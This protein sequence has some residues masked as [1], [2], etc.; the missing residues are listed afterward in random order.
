LTQRAGSLS[1]ITR[2]STRTGPGEDVLATLDI[3]SRDLDRQIPEVLV[4][5]RHH[6]NLGA[7]ELAAVGSERRETGLIE[8]ITNQ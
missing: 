1:H 4:R 7:R 2:C 8:A 6:E 3:V 5:E